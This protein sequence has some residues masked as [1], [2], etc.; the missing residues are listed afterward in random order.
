MALDVSLIHQCP[1]SDSEQPLELAHQ[2]KGDLTSHFSWH[3]ALLGQ[4]LNY[5]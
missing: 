1:A 2:I 5:L 3:P 4:D